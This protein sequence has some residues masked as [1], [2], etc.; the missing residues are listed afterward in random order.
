MVESIRNT[1]A[2]MVVPPANSTGI[3]KNPA[4]RHLP[5]REETT[6]TFLGKRDHDDSRFLEK[7]SLVDIYA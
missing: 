4:G 1:N 6:L 2:L 3:A 7:G 5:Q